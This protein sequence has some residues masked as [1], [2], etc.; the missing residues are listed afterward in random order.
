MKC[1][2]RKPTKGLIIASIIGLC[3]SALYFAPV[4]PFRAVYYIQRYHHD[5]ELCYMHIPDDVDVV[6][7]IGKVLAEYDETHIII[8]NKILI[9]LRLLLD[10]DSLRNYTAKIGIKC[11]DNNFRRHPNPESDLWIEIKP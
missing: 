7:S 11:P 9:P 2:W 1:S 6:G 4:F 10:K 8:R 5:Q 3:F